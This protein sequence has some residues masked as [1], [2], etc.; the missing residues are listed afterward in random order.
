MATEQVK[1]EDLGGGDTIV[2]P[3]GGT[4]VVVQCVEVLEPG[5]LIRVHYVPKQATLG[6]TMPRGTTLTRRKLPN[7]KRPPTVR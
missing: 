4:W 6:V 3:F 5:N 7:A 1:I 2:H